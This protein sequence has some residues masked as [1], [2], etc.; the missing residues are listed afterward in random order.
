MIRGL[1]FFAQLAVLVIGAVWLAEQ[2]GPVSVE[3]HGWLME[4][5]AGVLILIVLVLSS[6]AIYLRN[7]MRKTLQMRTI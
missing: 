4:T 7:R 3:W 5:S 2:Q 6:L 1:W